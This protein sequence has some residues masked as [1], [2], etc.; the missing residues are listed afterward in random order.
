MRKLTVLFILFTFYS[1]VF[2][3]IDKILKNIPGVDN[4][5][6]DPPVSTSIK[7]AYPQAFFLKNLD[8]ELNPDTSQKYSSDLSSGYY[9][10][11]FKTFC[12][13]SGTY[14]SGK[15]D[16]FLPAPLKGKKAEL[17]QNILNRYIEH[18]E[19]DQN[20][21][22]K[23]IWGIESGMKFSK[24]PKDFQLR[25]KPL[26]SAE[27]IAA[28]EIDVYEIAKDLVPHLPKEVKDLL[29]LYNEINS[30]LSSASSSYEDIERLAIKQ[31][32][33]TSGKGSINVER[34]TWAIMGNGVYLRCLPQGYR[35]SII[36]EYIPVNITVSRDAKNRITSMDD[37]TN[38]IDITYDDSEGSDS[39]NGLPI[40]RF[41]TIQVTGLASFT[42]N[43]IGWYIPS[44]V[45]VSGTSSYKRYEDASIPEYNARIKA[46]DD[47]IKLVIKT[48][49][50]KKQKELN[51][52]DINALK[53]LKHFEIALRFIIGME[54]ATE[55]WFQYD[56]P[57]SVNALYNFAGNLI[58]GKLKGGSE[59][60]SGPIASITGLVFVPGNTSLQRLGTIGDGGTPPPVSENENNENNNRN[61]NEESSPKIILHQVT[62]HEMLPEPNVDYTAELEIHSKKPV[63]EIV[64]DLYE[65]SRE[66][67][68][69]LND[70][71]PQF[72]KNP[73][74]ADFIFDPSMNSGYE[75][76][77][78]SYSD[79]FTATGS[80]SAPRQ[81][82]IQSKDYG[83]FARL[84][85]RVKIN[86][87]WYNAKCEGWD[88]EYIKIP[89]DMND[90]NV[91]DKWENDNLVTG[92]PV[93]YDEDNVP[94][95]QATLGDGMTLY[96][97]YRGFYELLPD[98]SVAHTRLD[99]NKKEI[100]VIDESNLASTYTWEQASGIALYR[101]NSSLVYGSLG[102]DVTN[103]E[104]RWVDFCRGYAPGTKYAINVI[105][106]NGLI[107]T[108]SL[109]SAE[110]PSNSY[111]GCSLLG[112][113]KNANLT[114]IL[115]DRLKD[116]LEFV[117]IY[118]QSAHD[119]NPN[120][121]QYDLGSVLLDSTDMN[122]YLNVFNT[123]VKYNFLF[124]Y[125]L[126]VAVVHEM[127]HACGID[128]HTP[129]TSGYQLC[130]M[131][132][133]DF[134]QD[135]GIFVYLYTDI[136]HQIDTEDFTPIVAEGRLHFCT[137]S[138]NSGNNCW[139]QIDVKD[140]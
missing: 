81:I 12:L 106:I 46:V 63:Q 138:N 37:G 38:K 122:Q 79:W 47:Y 94:S 108:Y 53:D 123:P 29:N 131:I 6:I 89:Y 54:D 17:I 44:G 128:H 113:P 85:A 127:G 87:T 10:F 26:L 41:K 129:V 27:E 93:D 130:P 2:S 84:K 18:P 95:G 62:L 120:Q 117:R 23:L 73:P 99:P 105:K 69:C 110:D 49:G 125:I 91:A 51:E 132:Y 66:N 116:W 121:S 48:L 102:G 64:F 45:K 21:V 137:P 50:K 11:K 75:I 9:R 115:P 86:G 70:K 56:Y 80:G 58:Q 112:P 124:E 90:N 19:I 140:R 136:L 61:P 98:G 24:Y 16:G 68:R 111:W 118:L 32:T 22:Q 55:Q 83:G 72:Y 134:T 36:E 8:K 88:K 25:V 103:P 97:E 74:D 39:F 100:F 14:S 135:V 60:S 30:K 42:K 31:G 114:I 96:E 57:L 15:D 109:C 82:I 28:M 7:D 13:K 20:D 40:W 76:S 104:Y 77:S 67:G 35:N 33:P 78:T 3:Q 139:H 4:V 43:D 119:A 52:S 1:T 107:D 59:K 65:I 5:R 71:D 126:K 92:F 101:L 34:G 133:F